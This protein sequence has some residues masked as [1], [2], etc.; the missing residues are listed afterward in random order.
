VLHYA[1]D[2]T[3]CKSRLILSYFGETDTKIAGFVR[4]VYQK[5][6]SRQHRN[7]GTKITALLKIQD[8]DSREIEKLSQSNSEAVIF[9]LQNLMENE[10][11][12]LKPNNQYRLK[13]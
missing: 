2:K 10:T 12:T 6:R 4:I 1:E 7:A 13:Q 11:I 3:T 9:A 5:R 8:L